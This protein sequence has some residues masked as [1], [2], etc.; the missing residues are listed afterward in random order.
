MGDGVNNTVERVWPQ[1]LSSEQLEHYEVEGFLLLKGAIEESLIARLERGLERNPPL[2]GTL[3]TIPDYPAPGR[4]T[5][6][7]SALQDPDLIPIVEHEQL[8]GGAAQLLGDRPKLTA[9]VIY[10]RT[11]GGAGLPAHHD[12]KRWRPV[13][14]SMN[15]LFTIIPF[16]AYDEEAGPLCIAP[17]SH[18]LERV[19]RGCERPFE[20]R[21]PVK[22]EA[23]DFIDPGLERGD[24]LYMNMHLWHYAAE[25]RSNRHRVGVFNKYAAASAPPATGYFLYNDAVR[26]ALKPENRDLLAVHSDLP[27]NSTRALLH[28]VSNGVDEVLL[29]PADD[30]SWTLPGGACSVEQAIPDWDG[31]NVIA[32]LQHHLLNDLAIETPWLSYVADRQEGGGLCRVYA[33]T[34]TGRGFPVTYEPARWFRA[35]EMASAVDVPDYISGL[36]DKWLDPAVVRGK[37]LSQA[38]SRIDQFAY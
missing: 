24:L 8:V 2:H 13:G 6:A 22:P 11:P 37:G 5:L 33:Y 34:L 38:R 29:V 18:H 21:P 35:G 1:P 15:W 16:C 14:S 32:S 31:G 36:L 7:E 3:G 12:Y 23:A 17:R 27:L 20:V 10:D 26:D 4:Y 28:R 19:Q 25:N 9:F 30:G